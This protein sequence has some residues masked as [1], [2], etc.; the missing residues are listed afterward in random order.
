MRAS[1]REELEHRLQ[2]ILD[3]PQKQELVGQLIG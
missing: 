3:L 1:A 2:P